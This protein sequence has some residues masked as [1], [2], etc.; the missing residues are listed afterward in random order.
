[1]KTRYITKVNRTRTR[2]Y[3]ASDRL[4]QLVNQNK[5]QLK[6]SLQKS[7]TKGYIYN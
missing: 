6:I 3:A 4:C 1:M 5:K 2:L 7:E